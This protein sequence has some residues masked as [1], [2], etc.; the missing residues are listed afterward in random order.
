MGCIRIILGHYG[1]GKTQI[2]VNLSLELAK[3]NKKVILADLDIVNPYFRTS[4]SA[5]LLETHGIRLIASDFGGNN[6]DLPSIP[7]AVQS[8]FDDPEAVTVMDVGGDDRGALALGRYA[9][10]LGDADILMVINRFRPQTAT[11]E[12]TLEIMRE[13]E[14]AAH[15]KIH[16][17]INNSNL[18]AETT[19]NDV[20]SSVKYAK[21][22]SEAS[23]LPLVMH[24]VCD[25]LYNEVNG[26]VESLFR[27]E[28]FSKKAWR[29]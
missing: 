12:G 29:I 18:G 21:S 23:G 15:V 9:D 19:A 7:P 6:L 14:A 4:D 25:R 24:T 5:E 8:A 27:L 10:K 16:G 28:I 26:K 20:I 22:V 1:S 17:F 2:A 3:T 13:I 11:V